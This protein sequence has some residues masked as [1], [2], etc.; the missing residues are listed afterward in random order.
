MSMIGDILSGRLRQELRTR[1][2]EVLKAGNEWNQTAHEL[3]QALNNLTD[4]IKSGNPEKA[5]SKVVA[6]TARKLAR[7][8]TR[9]TKAFEDHNQTLEKIVTKFG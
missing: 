3:T 9:L 8:T 1:V 6:Q 4:A 2:D 5:H 7:E